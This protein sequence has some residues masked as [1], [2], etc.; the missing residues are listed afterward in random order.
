MLC[1]SDPAIAISA[2]IQAIL[3]QSSMAKMSQIV[4]YTHGTHMHVQLER[5][6]Q[7]RPEKPQVLTL[8]SLLRTL[9]LHYIFTQIVVCCCFNAL[10][11][12]QSQAYLLS[13]SGTLNN[14]AIYLAEVKC[15]NDCYIP[16]FIN[17][18]LQNLYWLSSQY[19]LHCLASLLAS[20]PANK[21]KSQL[22]VD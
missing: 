6:P 10:S 7:Q 21:A 2:V 12:L 9:L 18:H 11:I 3:S 19:W 5:L 14:P 17:W 8:L 16:K 4:G 15:V 20:Q 1:F 22:F 13:Y